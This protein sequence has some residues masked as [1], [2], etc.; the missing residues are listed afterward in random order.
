MIAY[1]KKKTILNELYYM[2]RIVI[3]LK[4][5]KI[6]VWLE[7]GE[8]NFKMFLMFVN[9]KLYYILKMCAKFNEFKSFLEWIF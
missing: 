1:K 9:T 2:N 6:Y 4:I 8:K 7:N 5:S 3:K